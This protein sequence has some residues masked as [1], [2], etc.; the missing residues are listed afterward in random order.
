M[1]FLIFNFFACFPGAT[2]AVILG[3]GLAVTAASTAYSIDA[4][5]KQEKA[6]NAALEYQ[7]KVKNRDAQI[8]NMNADMVEKQGEIDEK[9]HRLKLKSLVGTQ[10]AAGAGSGALVDMDTNLDLTQDTVGFGEIDA[11]TIRRNASLDAYN[12]RNQA[13]NFQAEAALARAKK[14]SVSQATTGS[15][16]TGASNLTQSAGQF[17]QTY[18]ASGAKT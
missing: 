12:V 6:Q 7:A 16:L 8:A 17:A 2:E 5:Q 1:D 10:R 18:K 9:Q 11:L 3:I 14:G 15:I 4:T 13:S